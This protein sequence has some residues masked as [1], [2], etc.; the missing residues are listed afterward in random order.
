[1]FVD[2]PIVEEWY[3]GRR[4]LRVVTLILGLIG[5]SYCAWAWSLKTEKTRTV[6]ALQEWN[7]GDHGGIVTGT[8]TSIE[9]TTKRKCAPVVK[10]K[11]M[12]S[13]AKT[14]GGSGGGQ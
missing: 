11:A 10:R 8:T 3:A 14:C 12:R 2:D 4:Q 6:A 9:T 1:M 7:T 5:L 13:K